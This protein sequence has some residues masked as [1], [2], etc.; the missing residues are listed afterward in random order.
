V[1]P[2]ID[3]DRCC[4]LACD[5]DKGSWILD[6]LAFLEVCNSTGVPAG[7]ERSRSGNGARVWVFFDG[8]VAATVARRLGTG[9][10][11]E[12]MEL[13]VEVDLTSY[14]RLFPSQ[15]SVPEKGFGNLIALPLQGRS[16]TEGNAA[17]LDPATL[18]P[19]TDQWAFL[20]AIRR[21]P[22]DEAKIVGEAIRVTAGPGSTAAI[23]V[24][25]SSEPGRLHRQLYPRASR[26]CS[27][28]T[29]LACH[30]PW[31]PH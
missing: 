6:A 23:G 9:L 25:H 27:L 18:E 11:R 21:L 16:R 29:E 26:A 8:P 19:W 24:K 7:L 28:S 31:L 5:F 30:P 2:L 10:L 4:F 22:T 3:G 15:D 13:R 12:T 1:Y 14:D 17:F 20:S